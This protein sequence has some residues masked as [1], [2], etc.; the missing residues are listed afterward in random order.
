MATA[1]K[2]ALKVML[3]LGGLALLAVGAVIAAQG[4]GALLMAGLLSPV[5]INFGPAFFEMLG[6][7]IAWVIGGAVMVLIGFGL[8][9]AAFNLRSISPEDESP[10]E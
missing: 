4:A 2:T 6:A 10:S 8:M 7:P 1:P 3:I 5:A 9:L